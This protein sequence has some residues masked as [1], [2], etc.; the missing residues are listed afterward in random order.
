MKPET[1]DVALPFTYLHAGRSILPIAPGYKAPSLVMASGEAVNIRWESFKRI[2][3]TPEEVASWFPP[4]CLMGIGIAMGPVSGNLV[5]GVQHGAE[6]IDFDD[7]ATLEQ[8]IE[9]AHW[10]GWSDLLHRLLFERTP[11]GSGHLAYQCSSWEGNVVL[12][13]RPGDVAAGEH[14]VVTLIETRGEGGQAVVAP[15]PPGIHR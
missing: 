14:P 2:P 6:V 13:R 3:A 11:R 15:T 12:A 10:H 9:A 1:L 5:D 7:T 4:A 8:F